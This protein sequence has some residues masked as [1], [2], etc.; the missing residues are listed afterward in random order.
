MQFSGYFHEY[1]VQKN[2]IYLK[3]IFCNI[4]NVFTVIFDQ[5]NESLLNKSIQK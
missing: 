4:I 2:S 1:K 5:M 3:Y